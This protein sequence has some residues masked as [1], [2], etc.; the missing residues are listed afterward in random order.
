[1]PVKPIK[2]EEE[3][4]IVPHQILADLRDEIDELKKRL[5]KPEEEVGK[6]L[7]ASMAELKL[8]LHDLLT[9]IKKAEEEMRK[10]EKGVD[11]GRA[12]NN[13]T[14]KVDELGHQNEEIAAAL[15]SLGDTVD[16]MSK[17]PA[18]AP[19]MP[20]PRPAPMPPPRA[21]PMPPPQP[22]PLPPEP[23]MPPGPP[24]PMPP[25][26]M[27]MPPPPPMGPPEPEKKKGFLG[28]LFKK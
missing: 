18:P 15:V 21:P 20:P 24:G 9:I 14:K 5:A 10:E 28:S 22:K 12:I 11:L 16:Q 17:R 25:P 4:E 7:L 1:M 13:L 8:S 27:G 19:M 23:E 3:Y 6:E 2:K 26:P